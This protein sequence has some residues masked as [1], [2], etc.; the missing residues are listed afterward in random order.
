M[1]GLDEFLP[2][3]ASIP[4]PVDLS[5]EL[6]LELLA[7]AALA[8]QKSTIQE[9]MEVLRSDTGR[10]DF[11]KVG[12]SDAPIFQCRCF[13]LI[14]CSKLVLFPVPTDFNLNRKVE[15]PAL[16]DERLRSFGVREN[17]IAADLADG[18]TLPNRLEETLMFARR[19]GVWTHF[20][21]RP[22]SLQRVEKALDGFLCRLRVEDRRL[23]ILEP[24]LHPVLG[25]PDTVA[26]DMTPEPDH[27]HRIDAARFSAKTVEPLRSTEFHLANDVNSVYATISHDA[28]LLH[29]GRLDHDVEAAT[30]VIVFDYHG[31]Q[32]YGCQ[33][34]NRF[35]PTPKGGGFRSKAW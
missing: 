4:L 26:T 17:K 15:P 22:P 32:L 28:L 12:G 27:R 35:I 1:F 18:D 29:K 5:R 24:F 33:M 9:E 6:R 21:G 13:R 34:E 30:M 23:S 10:M 19:F 31:S 25:E 11:T 8:A 7:V 14:G 3:F 16:D 2:A 20:L